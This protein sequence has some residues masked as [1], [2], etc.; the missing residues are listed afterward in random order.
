MARDVLT[1][2]SVLETMALA[3][4]EG[5]FDAEMQHRA[6]AAL[7]AGKVVCAPTLGFVVEPAERNLLTPEISAQTRKN[8]SFNPATG[9]VSKVHLDEAA[10]ASLKHM[11][12]RYAECSRSLLTMLFPAYAPFLERAR[13]SFRPS[14]IAGRHY[15]KRKDDR[16]LH[17]DA[18]PSTPTRGKRILRVFANIAPD[19]A[20]RHWRVGEAFATVAAQY[21]PHLSLPPPGTS[22]LLQQ[23][24]VTKQRR[25]AYDHLMLR[26]HDSLKRDGDFQRTAPYADIM[27]PSNSVWICFTDQV[28]HSALSGHCALEQTFYVPVNALAQ[29]ETSP[30]R[31]LERISGKQ[32]AAELNA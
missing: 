4:W 17:V 13:T 24:G 25:A 12:M 23:V 27:F 28:L 2:S 14:E 26:L 9:K 1:L 15:S 20:A 3:N 21:M 7:E 29:P 5:P 18:F 30:L 32:L 10:I 22:W 6:Q 16:R 11:M 31:V 19:G 8:I